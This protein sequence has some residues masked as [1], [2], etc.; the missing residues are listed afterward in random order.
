MSFRPIDDR[1]GGP[2]QQKYPT[3]YPTELPLRPNERP[4]TY[5]SGIYDRGGYGKTEYSRRNPKTWSKKC[6]II[7]SAVVVILL[8]IIVAVAVSVSRA[9]RYPNY[10]KLNYSLTDT[11]AGTGFFDNFDYFTG[12]DPAGG[13]VHYVDGPGSMAQNLTYASTTSAVLRVDTSDT[14]SSTGR[15][16]VKVSSKNTYNTGLF[17]F[18]VIHSPYGCST[19]P[20][21]WMTDLSNW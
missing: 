2:H 16:S 9:N 6:W 17:V 8:V 15:L 5:T 20:A 14:D 11:Y 1:Y 10:S 18:D 7:L 4:P 13:F 21:L 12:Y 19:W 3:S